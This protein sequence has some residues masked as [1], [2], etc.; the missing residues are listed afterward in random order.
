[1]LPLGRCWGGCFDGTVPEQEL[2]RPLLIGLHVRP[3]PFLLVLLLLWRWLML[4]RLLR[5][6]WGEWGHRWG[7]GYWQHLLLP[8]A[9]LLL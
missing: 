2:F 3:P 5:L 9:V 1:M 6:L 4:W 8:L 7:R